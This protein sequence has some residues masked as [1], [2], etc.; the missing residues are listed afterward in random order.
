[1]TPTLYVG[2]SLDILPTLPDNSV[3]SIVTDP[4][5]EISFMSRKWDATGIAY[6]VELWAECLRVLKPG[7]HLLSFG[8]PRTY[9]RM[10][11]AIEDVGFEIRDSIH[12]THGA[13]FPKSLDVSKGID[14]GAGAE[15]EVIERKRVKGGGMESVN[16][17]NA[18]QH[19][20][21]PD[22]YQKGENVLDVT[23][24]ATD[25][26]KRWA[27]WGTGLKPSHEPIVVA[28]KPLEG[29][30]VANILEYGAGAI[31][32]DGCRVGVADGFGGGAKASGGFVDGYQSDGFVASSQGRWPANTILGHAAACVCVGEQ[33]VK[34]SVSVRRNGVK[35]NDDTLGIARGLFE[36]GAKDATLGDS[37]GNETVSVWRCVDGCPVRNLDGQSGKVKGGTWNR[38]KGARHFDN[39]GEPTE[40]ETAGKDATVGGASRFFQ[41]VEWNPATDDLGTLV[42][43][44]KPN[45]K[46]RPVVDGVSHA[47]VK[48]LAL[49]RYL[50]RLVTPVGGI[51]LDPFAGSGTTMEA[52]ILEGMVPVGVEL[53]AE[54]VPLIEARMERQGAELAVIS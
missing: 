38:T 2:N 44:S 40:Y 45:K 25:D 11:C 54:H 15:R 37:E 1:M 52:A 46:E 17:A 20:Y 18:D 9:H 47:T 50:V 53:T 29:T 42:Y 30:V 10:A 21:R 4:P 49:M 12:W 26:A 16:R 51:V 33:K 24:P 41:N 22:G 28:R 23:A 31:N 35:A 3:D 36:A 5:Y 39:D 8:S 13:G 27:G 34:A 6:S 7:G 32:I 48:P 19:G 43:V 14:K